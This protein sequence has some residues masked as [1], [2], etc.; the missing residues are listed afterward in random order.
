M[1]DALS[2]TPLGVFS[3]NT[4]TDVKVAR[5]AIGMGITAALAQQVAEDTIT[6][7]YP[8]D[9]AKRNAMIAAGIPEYSIRIG[10]TWY[11]Y[12]RV[13]PL[14]TVMGSTVDGI[15]AVRDYVQKPTY[16]SKKEKDLVIDVVAGV[17]K[18][19]ASKTF[20]E[21]ISGV[22]QALHDPERYGGS[23]V[24]SFAGLLVPS[25]V[26]A[27]ARTQDPY[28]RVVTSFGEAVQ[29]RV[30]DLGLGLPIPARTDLPVQSKLFG[31]ARENPA[32]GLAAFTGIQSTPA[33]RNAVQEEV[34][35]TKVDY[36]LP[37]KTLR[38]VELEGV[39]QARYQELS[40]QY[41]DTILP[42][43]IE[44]SGYQN[45]PDKL[46]KVILERGLRSA[47]KAATRVMLG[48]KLQDPDFRT[49]FIRARLEKKGVEMEE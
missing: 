7:S 12:A 18:N 33:Q 36:N 25:F 17:T 11:S 23:F 41:A 3:K 10:D 16:D 4:P 40:S 6:G 47:R 13:E 44:S 29:A 38:G 27:I 24:N 34:A 49:Q 37:S 1:K 32:Y 21:G 19:I 39:D 2:Y 26:G 22:M 5:T 42:R 46:K 35:R 8:K 15:N 45:A 31:G 28:S 14:A 48:E 43:I 9:A 30:P 20:L